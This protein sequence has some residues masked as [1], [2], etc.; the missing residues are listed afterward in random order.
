M[1]LTEDSS[2]AE[3]ATQTKET[4]AELGRRLAAESLPRAYSLSA[5]TVRKTIVKKLSA[6]VRLPRASGSMKWK[7]KLD[8]APLAGIREISEG[9]RLEQ[10]FPLKRMG[11]GRNAKVQ[12]TWSTSGA[13]ACSKFGSLQLGHPLGW[14]GAKLVKA[15]KSAKR[16]VS[17][18]MTLLAPPLTVTQ[19]E[20]AE[21]SSAT[22]QG[23]LVTYSETGEMRLPPNHEHIWGSGS[24]ATTK[25]LKKYAKKM[26]SGMYEEGMP[27]SQR[28][29]KAMGPEY[30]SSEEESEGEEEEEV[31]AVS[32]A[33]DEEEREEP[34]LDGYAEFAD[35]LHEDEVVSLLEEAME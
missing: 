3:M 30:P 29:K 26:I 7:L 16:K 22:I 1:D 6:R 21:E 8:L 5:R 14:G 19:T 20:G 28:M 32:L 18:Q 17:R 4:P 15:P 10:Q 33:L 13:N 11:S 25:V 24:A 12:R 35:A 23:Y 31:W 2:K 34:E 27:L 9:A